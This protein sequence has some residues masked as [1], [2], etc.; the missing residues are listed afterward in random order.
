MRFAVVLLALFCFNSQLSGQSQFGIFGGPQ[1]TTARYKIGSNEQSTSSKYGFQVGAGWK[2]AFDNQLYFAPAVAYSM[3]GYKVKLDEPSFPPHPQ[4]VNNDMRLHTLELAALLQYDL[5][6]SA[7]HFFIKAGPTLD[8]QLKGK[9]K[10]EL[11]NKDVIEK[12]VTFDFGAYGR[13]AASF[14]FQLGY[15][16]RSGFYVFG[17]YTHGVGSINNADHGPRILH[18]G[19]GI[20]I[21]QYLS[22]K[23]ATS[24][25]SGHR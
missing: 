5:G 3:K 7:N 24:P 18:R 21:G 13:Y 25:S 15:E 1:V 14:L 10:F 9:E 8:F 2:I 23:I 16:T 19:F 17:Q 22:K 4:A 6:K 11:T 12:N 20:S